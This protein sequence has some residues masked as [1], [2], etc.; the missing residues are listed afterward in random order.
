MNLELFITKAVEFDIED[1]TNIKAKAYAD[2]RKK[3]VPVP[4][5]TPK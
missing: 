2:D 5:E 3:S 4:E 1:F